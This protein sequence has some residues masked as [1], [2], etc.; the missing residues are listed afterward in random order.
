MIIKLYV[1]QPAWP[2]EGDLNTPNDRQI[3]EAGE[4]IMRIG[5]CGLVMSLARGMDLATRETDSCIEAAVGEGEKAWVVAGQH[6]EVGRLI[7]D[8]FAG[9]Y[10]LDQWEIE[11]PP[12]E[13]P[14][15]VWD[16][17]WDEA[18]GDDLP[19]DVSIVVT[20]APDQGVWEHDLPAMAS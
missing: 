5:Q 6:R 1:H 18:G 2:G 17:L 15:D 19:S 10:C 13:D 14:E 11:I 12:G 7:R 4:T 3:M 20:A 8:S 16:L 9:G